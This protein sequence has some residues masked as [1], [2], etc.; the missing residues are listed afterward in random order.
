M[1]H[2]FNFDDKYYL[3]DSESGSL[4][5]SDALTIEVVKKLKGEQ[6]CLDGVDSE[7]VKE[8]EEVIKE[9]SKTGLH[10]AEQK[11]DVPIKSDLVK[12]LCLHTSH[13]CNL[14]CQYCFAE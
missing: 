5:V 3:F 13:D 1:V 9:I 7:V 4:Y 11:T 6:Y 14:A 8:I 12:A 10:F 2:T